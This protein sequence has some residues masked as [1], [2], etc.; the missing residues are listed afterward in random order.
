MMGAHFDKLGSSIDKSAKAYNDM[1]G[2]VRVNVM[3][4]ARRFRDL[5]HDQANAP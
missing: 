2:S 1:I 5:Q 4:K 3:P